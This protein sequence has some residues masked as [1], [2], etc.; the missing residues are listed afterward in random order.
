MM[1][2]KDL[3]IYTIYIE[4]IILLIILF[5][6]FVIFPFFRIKEVNL[7]D[8]EISISMD[9]LAKAGLNSHTSFLFLDEKKIVN[10]I[11]HEPMV[12]KAIVEKKFPDKL[13]ITVFGRKALAMAYTQVDSVIIPLSF[14]ENGVLFE[15]GDEVEIGKLPII[16]GDL[17]FSNVT[18]GGA[19]PRSIIPVLRDLKDIRLKTPDLYNSISEIYV[20]KKGESSFDMILFFTF[21]TIKARIGSSL[22][23]SQLE[24]IIVVNSLLHRDKTDIDEVDFRSREFIYRESN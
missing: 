24:S 9:D 3:G 18:K 20:E 1:N 7:I 14:D 19:L 21:T 4:G 8:S 10:N 6:L 13:E 11:E 16:S 12:R 2:I 5:S 23:S 15:M 22:T 17:D